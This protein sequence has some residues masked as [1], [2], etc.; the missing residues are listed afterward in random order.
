M[1]RILTRDGIPA[2]DAALA[3]AAPGPPG[4]SGPAGEKH[5]TASDVLFRG[6]DL[7]FAVRAPK[8]AT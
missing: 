2:G 3:F 6:P 7:P 4:A 1:R 5:S 8:E